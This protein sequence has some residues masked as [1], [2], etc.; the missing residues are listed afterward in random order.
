MLCTMAEVSESEEEMAEDLRRGLGT[1]IFSESMRLF[2]LG[3]EE[4]ST[5]I[6]VPSSNGCLATVLDE[7]GPL[8]VGVRN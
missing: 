1:S 2:G 8:F 5:R 7:G 6:A 3:G 4:S